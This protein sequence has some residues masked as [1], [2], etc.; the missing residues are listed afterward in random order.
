MAYIPD[1]AVLRSHELSAAGFRMYAYF[2]MRRSAETGTCYPSLSRTAEDLKMS[3]THASEMRTNLRKLEWIVI[4]RNGEVRP[5]VG[6]EVRQTPKDVSANAEVEVSANAEESFSECRTFQQTPNLEVSANAEESF[7]KNRTEFQQMPNSISANAEVS[8]EPAP[9]TSPYNQPIE[10]TQAAQPAAEVKGS[11]Q[12]RGTRIPENYQPSE[13]TMAWAV[14]NG[15]DVDI[16]F[17]LDE[18][19]DYWRSR[20]TNATKLDWDLTFKN[21][22]RACQ[23]HVTEQKKRDERLSR[24]RQAKPVAAALVGK[25]V[26]V[27]KPPPG[28]ATPAEIAEWAKTAQAMVSPTKTL[29]AAV[30]EVDDVNGGWMPHDDANRVRKFLGLPI[31]SKRLESVN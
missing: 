21:R 4:D 2:C 23:N 9:L 13:E 8:I 7:G 26:A 14:A 11:K 27:P 6:F 5:L 29:A 16:A 19:R 17:R 10:P 20:P 28:P 31:V 24:I 25:P 18:F 12:I 22:I 15:P 3:Y 1:V 30:D